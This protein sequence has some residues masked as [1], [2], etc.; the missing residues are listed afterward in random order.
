MNPQL[1]TSSDVVMLLHMDALPLVDE[2]GRV[3]T[4]HDSGGSISS[5]A[6]GKF[7]NAAYW[8]AARSGYATMVNDE[9][10]DFGAGP[11]PTFDVWLRELPSTDHDNIVF[12]VAKSSA[13]GQY[14]MVCLVA[15]SDGGASRYSVFLS[16][17]TAGNAFLGGS[18]ALY[19][20]ALRPVGSSDSYR[21]VRFGRCDGTTW[22]LAVDG[23]I[24]STYTTAPGLLFNGSIGSDHG[25]TWVGNAAASPPYFIGNNF[26]G[27]PI[28]EL[29]ARKRWMDMADF[30]PP[31]TRFEYP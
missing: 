16:D 5:I 2:V 22:K 26:S 17:T 11:G 29:V 23:L 1:Y 3:V 12:Q 20:G 6:G 13:S 18:Y 31:A 28:D 30:T 27:G 19:S 9:R 21:H 15:N 25:L 24:K 14:G 8:S 10:M 4:M 7:G